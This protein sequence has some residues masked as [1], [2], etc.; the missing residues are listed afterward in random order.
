MHISTFCDHEEQTAGV[1]LVLKTG[2]THLP[3]SPNDPLLLTFMLRLRPPIVLACSSLI[4]SLTIAV[5]ARL[6]PQ[7]DPSF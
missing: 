6:L 4:C 7:L 3:S 2:C 5:A 1:E